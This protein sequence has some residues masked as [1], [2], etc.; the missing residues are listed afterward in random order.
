MLQPIEQSR[1]AL[2]AVLR[3]GVERLVAQAMDVEFEQFRERFAHLRDGRGREA[4]VRNGF[5]PERTIS[6][7]LGPIAVRIPKVRCRGEDTPA[8]R[9]FLV[10]RY[11]HRPRALDA[12][13]PW[14]YLRGVSTGDFSPVLASIAEWRIAEICF[15]VIDR[16]KQLWS[17]EHQV[18]RTDPLGRSTW[19][20]L[21]A[22]SIGPNPESGTE[23]LTL[24]V[25]VGRDARG[26]WR[27]LAV[28]GCVRQS[29]RAWREVLLALR[30]RG[31]RFP[32]AFS[33]G[34]DVCGFREAVEQMLPGTK[35]R[36]G[37]FLGYA[38]P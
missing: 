25:I 38:T 2:T 9:S 1:D 14:F 18:R 34:N 15:G 33:A 17:E 24:L 19:T 26:E 6:T 21:W 36:P 12:A 16:L 31:L 23:D 37:L 30:A 32:A 11:V 35:S 10:P 5:H 8:F 3:K 13:L 22:G 20:S 29:I 27:L 28:D 7:S 4:I